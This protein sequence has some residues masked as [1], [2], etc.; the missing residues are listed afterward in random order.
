[1]SRSG[2]SD[3]NDNWG[4]WRGA[5]LSAINGK[6]GQA[7]LKELLIDLDA[8]EHKQLIVGTLENWGEF[9]TMG[10]IGNA[11][12]IDMKY[13]DP[14]AETEFSKAFGISEAMAKE[15]VF[16]NDEYGTCG[17]LKNETPG[18]RWIR[19]RQWVAGNITPELTRVER[20]G[21]GDNDGFFEY[22]VP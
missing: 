4:L 22:E 9:C 21:A 1:M 6:R 18:E 5:V 15:I 12:G 17:R 11:R 20:K 2:Y 3:D 19:M 14:C 16:M 10:V 13:L 8:M 7:F